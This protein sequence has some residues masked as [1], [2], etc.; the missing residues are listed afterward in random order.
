MQRSARL[1][2]YIPLLLIAARVGAQD[3]APMPMPDVY[4]S[5]NIAVSEILGSEEHSIQLD[6]PAEDRAYYFVEHTE[7]LL[8]GFGSIKLFAGSRANPEG[9]L[10]LGIQTSAP[11]NF[12]R[13]FVTDDES[14]PRLLADDDGD[15]IS[16][17][18]EAK[19]GWDAYEQPA[20]LTTDTDNDGMPD[21][22]E[23][24]HF[25]NL[26]QDGAGDADGDGVSNGREFSFGDNPGAEETE[27]TVFQLEVERIKVD[28][29]AYIDLA[30]EFIYDLNF[31]HATGD[32]FYQLKERKYSY[33]PWMDDNLITET[34]ES[35]GGS[36]WV[37]DYFLSSEDLDFND[38]SDC[39]YIYGYYKLNNFNGASLTLLAKHSEHEEIIEGKT[40]T[41]E[42][43]GVVSYEVIRWDGESLTIDGDAVTLPTEERDCKY[44][45]G[46]V[47]LPYRVDLK[48]LV[49]E[50]PSG[51]EVYGKF[52]EPQRYLKGRRINFKLDTSDGIPDSEVSWAGT[53]G[54]TN[55]GDRKKTWKVYRES[56]SSSDTDYKSVIAKL[57]ESVVA[58]Q[59]LLVCQYVLGI[60]SNVAPNANFTDGHAWITI[61]AWVDGI[62]SVITKYGLWPD[63]HPR[64]I[65]NGDASDVRNDLEET[66]YG[67]Y[68]RFYLLKPSQFQQLLNYITA[69]HHWSYFN[70]CADFVE[71]A[72]RSVIGENVD[73]SDG[74]VFGTPRSISSSIINLESNNPTNE[75]EPRDSGAVAESSSSGNSSWGGSSFIIE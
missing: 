8:E 14:H 52:K 42:P 59:D 69:D 38:D 75:Y 63:E 34:I 3:P 41:T 53:F 15:K 20:D 28:Y 45:Y 21:Y 22:W 39:Y 36:G 11:R 73:S 47:E 43:T 65:D 30:D 13:L 25:G 6:W 70:T 56:A 50:N 31:A 46:E 57:R 48:Y 17:L 72:V 35:S 23:Q 55:V 51:N 40:I 66:N 67:R 54:L 32:A 4:G 10:G 5:L 1:L 44:L 29:F 33:Y 9:K 16:N 24:F 62:N 58:K 7:D 2:Q 27:R 37:T 19:A 71:G 49:K 61:A 64:T 60:H 68:N 74:Y 18:L 12:Y 26:N